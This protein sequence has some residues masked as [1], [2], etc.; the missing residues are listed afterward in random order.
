MPITCIATITWPPMKVTPV[1][2]A[3]HI[4][5][6]AFKTAVEDGEIDIQFQDHTGIQFNKVEI[7]ETE[8]PLDPWPWQNQIGGYLVVANVDPCQGTGEDGNGNKIVASLDQEPVTLDRRNLTATAQ[9]MEI[10]ITLTMADGRIWEGSGINPASTVP[11]L[12][13]TASKVVFQMALMLQ[14]DAAHGR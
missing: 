1:H 8:V 4:L 11:L 13:G 3:G 14:E 6:R 12:T 2:D 10:D 9:P 5:I 7:P